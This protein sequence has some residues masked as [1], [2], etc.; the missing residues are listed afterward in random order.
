[1][2]SCRACT[3]RRRKLGLTSKKA[4]IKTAA[5]LAGVEYL[6]YNWVEGLEDEPEV[7]EAVMPDIDI[8]DL[9]WGF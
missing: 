8:S 1:M 7:P 2:F 5:E 9:F 3:A 6:S 4:G